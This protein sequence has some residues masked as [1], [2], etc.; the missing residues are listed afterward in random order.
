MQIIN[1]WSEPGAPKNPPNE[2]IK[3]GTLS[4]GIPHP[5]VYIIDAEQMLVAKYFEDD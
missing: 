1:K 3:P 4:Y 5:G 2:I